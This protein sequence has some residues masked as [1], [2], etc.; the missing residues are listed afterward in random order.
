MTSNRDYY[1]VLGVGRTAT[2][3]EIKAAYRKL[4]R[5]FHPDVN[6]GDS[7]AED[8]FKEVAE[9]FAV[10]GDPE[11]RARY[12]RGGR[13]A[14]GAGFDPFAG[15]SREQAEAFD[16]GGFSDLFESLFGGAAR[17]TRPRGRGRGGDLEFEMTVPFVQAISGHTIEVTLPRPGARGPGERVK[18]RIPPG[19]EDGSRVRVAGR[20]ESGHGGGAAGDAYLRVHVE[21]HPLFRREGTDLLCD[22]PVGIVKA[23]L[24]GR[25]DVPTLDGRATIEIP[26]GT[27]SGQKL[28][29]R[30]RGVPAHGARR[31]GDL[32]VVVQIVPPKDLDARSKA[33]LEEL[34]KLHPGA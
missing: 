11:K 25:V 23:T 32:F 30:G 26:P 10:L 29:L 31:A 33:L 6:P 7:A 8:R 12:D 15:M 9:A 3:K 17:G 18:V 13:E 19:V 34:A 4:A 16:F 20:G 1:E 22:V 28:R 14:F 24:G 27:R 2:E 5:K 21:P